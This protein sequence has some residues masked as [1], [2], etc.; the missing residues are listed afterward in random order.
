M[1][2]TIFDKSMQATA[3]IIAQAGKNTELAKI[4]K[5]LLQAKQNPATI[6]VCGEFKRGKS[7]FVNALIGR[8]I[9]PTDVDICTSVVSIIKYGL[10]EKV[11]RY[12]GDFAN[13]KSQVIDLDDLERFTVGSANEIDNTIYVEI[14]LPLERLK[15]G[16]VVID[17]P[18]VGGLDPRHATLTNYFLPQA[19]ITI[20][21]TDVNE[22]LTTT[23]LDFYKDKVM[24]YSKH[25]LVVINK[26]DLK[27]ATSVEEIRQDTIHKIA[28]YTQTDTDNILT[29]SVS[30][31]AEVY[32]ESDMGESH[33]DELRA[34]IVTLVDNFRKGILLGI[35]DN[36]VELLDLVIT[37]LQAQLAQIQSPDVDQLKC[38]VSQKGEMEQKLKDLRNPSSTFR[39]EINKAIN[40]DKYTIVS[41][42]NEAS[43]TLQ[44]EV[45][46]QLV[47]SPQARD[48]DGGKW[49]GRQLND[50]LAE[51]ASDITLELNR[52]FKRIAALPQFEGM[53]NYTAQE[54]DGRLSVRKVNT[55]VPFHKRVMPLTSGLGVGALAMCVGLSAIPVVGWVATF[56]LSA[57]VAYKNSTD[58]A[59]AH[60]EMN[61]RQMYQQQL[62][63][64][65]ANLRTYVDTRFQ[66]FQQEWLQVL[67]D[68]TQA[69]SD[70]MDDAIK[71]INEV[72]Q[73]IS[74]AVNLRTALQNKLNPLNT[75]KKDLMA[76]E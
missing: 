22:P 52:A 30:A 75:A 16:I 53:L 45:F 27:D 14:E 33:F 28:V 55:S 3:S 9:C 18:G 32:P 73:N 70:S 58:T 24:P 37:P 51:I 20:F 49:L 19:D 8:T 60:I 4:S 57:F 39:T 76:I 35:R 6:L 7:T 64:A 67:T 2:T 31:A 50:A 10:K 47:K 15:E 17:T 40:E 65:L 62:S 13:I 74:Q 56:G 48:D 59:H 23:E 29:V 41:M 54:F 21:M 1:D 43:V 26:S 66:E 72:K 68:R 12:Y 63:G 46:N 25:T 42:L 71:K 69:Y 34:T 44:S 38:F 5:L 11:T 61:L 36:Y